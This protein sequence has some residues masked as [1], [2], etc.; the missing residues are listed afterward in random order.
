M[1]QHS[2]IEWTDHSFNPWWGCA[3]VSPGCQHCYAET[4]ARRYRYDVWGTHAPRRLFGEQHWRAPLTWNQQAARQ[5][6]RSRVFCASMADVFEDHPDV[7]AERQRLWELIEATRMLD[8]LLLTK[9]PEQMQRLVPLTWQTGWPPNAWAL[10]SVENQQQAER[11]IPLL[12]NVPAVIRGLSLEPLI[13]PVDL[14][15]WL[16]AI[17]WGIVG[18]ESGHHA[19]PLHPEWVRSLR[20]QFQQ[21]QVAFF[22]KQ[23]GAYTPT[24][25]SST[26]TVAFQ[27]TGK[28]AAGRLLDGRTWDGIPTVSTAAECQIAERAAPCAE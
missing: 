26:G 14:S 28:K 2:P 5:Q 18:G 25:D 20:D 9:R 15:P 6:R 16:E 3:H 10:V 17:H 11:R 19:R 21:L 24:E 13:G 12:L 1:A 7:A 4:W 22:F 8:W 27:R 23:W